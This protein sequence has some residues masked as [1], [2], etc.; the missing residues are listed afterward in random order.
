[1]HDIQ[2]TVVSPLLR[3]MLHS[4]VLTPDRLVAASSE[5]LAALMDEAKEEIV[6]PRQGWLA[7][8]LEAARLAHP[9]LPAAAGAVPVPVQGQ[10]QGIEA[11]LQVAREMAASLAAQHPQQQHMQQQGLAGAATAGQPPPPPWAPQPSAKPLLRAR[12]DT[13]EVD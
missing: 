2:S 12:S 10:G 3:F 5:E 6:R 4:G 9:P 13:M 1:M 7:G 8:K 11:A